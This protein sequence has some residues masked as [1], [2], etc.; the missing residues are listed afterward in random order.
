MDQDLHGPM[1]FK[2]T[3]DENISNLEGY[4]WKLLS[5]PIRQEKHRKKKTRLD[6]VIVYK[7]MRNTD[8]CEIYIIM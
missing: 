8:L 7:I 2:G 6:E 3:L 4:I 1:D 5:C